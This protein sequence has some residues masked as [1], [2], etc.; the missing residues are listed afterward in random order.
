MYGF[1]RMQKVQNS[2]NTSRK[3]TTKLIYKLDFK[4]SKINSCVRNGR[5]RGHMGHSS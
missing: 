1:A 4:C 2:M 3:I 5:I